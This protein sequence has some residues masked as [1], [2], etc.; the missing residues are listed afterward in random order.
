MNSK[1]RLA[2]AALIHDIGKLGYRAR[3]KGKHPLF[4]LLTNDNPFSS[5]FMF[6]FLEKSHPSGTNKY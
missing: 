1:S 6:T 3:E 4:F 2:I 5:S